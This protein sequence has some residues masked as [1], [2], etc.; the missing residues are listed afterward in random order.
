M[1]RR[2]EIVAELAVLPV[3][4][5]GPA[6]GA[7]VVTVAVAIVETMTV[8]LVVAEIA[9]ASVLVVQVPEHPPVYTDVSDIDPESVITKVTVVARLPVADEPIEMPSLYVE[10]GEVHAPT[11]MP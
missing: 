11:A 1:P 9:S 8:V 10:H 3:S 6:V 4:A 7:D 5:V 2:P